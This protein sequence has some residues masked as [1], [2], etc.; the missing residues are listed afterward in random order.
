[1]NSAVILTEE[2][3]KLCTENQRRKLKEQHRR[4]YIAQ[5]GILQAQQGQFLV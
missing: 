5:R 2:N 3:K 1:M 4:R